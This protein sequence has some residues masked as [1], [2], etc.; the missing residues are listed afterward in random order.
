MDDYGEISL[1]IKNP[2]N[3]SA[4]IQLTDINDN[5]IAQE[6]TSNSN[7]ISFKYLTPKKY[8]IRIIYD[9]N[10]NGKWDTGNYLLKLHPESVEYFP[11]IQE[12]RAN[13][14]MNEEIN[15]K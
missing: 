1:S 4:I 10:T 12:V 3:T 2:N 14:V 5:T 9:T 15:I 6:S 8:K 7:I 11:E 13:W